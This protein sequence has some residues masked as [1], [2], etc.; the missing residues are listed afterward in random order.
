MANMD[1]KQLVTD[2]ASFKRKFRWTFKIEG[3]PTHFVKVA[4]R[5]NISID[6]TEINYLNGKTWIPGK[7]SFETLS[8]TFYDTKEGLEGLHSWI[9]SVYNFSNSNQSHTKGSYAKEGVLKMLDGCGSE[10]ET[11]TFKDLWPQAVN[12]GDLDYSSSDEVNVEV[13]FRYSE[14]SNSSLAGQCG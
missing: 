5:P 6:E 2:S 8:V 14:V 3:I 9:G 10:M 1:V 11:W 13:T 7:A 12:F 4:S